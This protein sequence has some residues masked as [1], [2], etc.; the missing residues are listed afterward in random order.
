MAGPDDQMPKP[1]EV[2]LNIQ[3]TGACR[4]ST[5]R[6]MSG[7]GAVGL[8][9]QVPTQ[10]FHQLTGFRELSDTRLRALG[11]EIRHDF[12]GKQ[13]HGMLDNTGIHSTELHRY[14]DVRRA[15]SP[16]TLHFAYGNIRRANHKR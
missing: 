13:P 2:V 6:A 4:S 10:D 15:H 14:H 7:P 11:T 16:D 8:F 9:R 1:G 12:A 3:H 5:G